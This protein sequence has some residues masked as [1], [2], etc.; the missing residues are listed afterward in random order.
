MLPPF[1]NPVKGFLGINNRTLYLNL[2][3]KIASYGFSGT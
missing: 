2:L 3:F 1:Q